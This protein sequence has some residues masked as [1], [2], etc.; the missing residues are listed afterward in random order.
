MH[1]GTTTETQ[2]TQHRE[3]RHTVRATETHDSSIHSAVLC[4]DYARAILAGAP[5]AGDP[6]AHN[7]HS[8]AVIHKFA[9]LSCE[10][11]QLP[12]YFP[13]RK[14]NM[15]E[16]AAAKTLHRSPTLG[17][18]PSE[19]SKTVPTKARNALIQVALE[20][21]RP[22]SKKAKNGTNLTLRYSKKALRLLKGRWGE[23][24]GW[25]QVG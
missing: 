10:A 21:L 23:R 9:L 16:V 5:N 19:E 15:A 12:E 14:I 25:G 20:I 24:G 8:P 11:S 3:T 6:P 13:R 7:P 1:H 22:S 18:V 4:G 17:G 2:N